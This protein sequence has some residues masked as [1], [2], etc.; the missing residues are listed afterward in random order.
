MNTPE[1]IELCLSR[2]LREMRSEQQKTNREPDMLQFLSEGSTTL[3]TTEESGQFQEHPV[4]DP[5][6]F[7]QQDPFESVSIQD[8]MHEMTQKLGDEGFCF[9]M[10]VWALRGL[11]PSSST[12]SA[13]TSRSP[14]R[15]RRARCRASTWC[16]T[17]CAR[18]RR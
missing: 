13:S 18:T 17:S 7:L 3:A 4:E 2:V 12:S 6:G 8:C 15:W 9:V 1:Q 14:E 11:N 10:Q 5:F 16:W